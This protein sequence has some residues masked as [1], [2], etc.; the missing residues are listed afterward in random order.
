MVLLGGKKE[1]SEELEDTVE[2]NGCWRTE[3]VV[4]KPKN[5]LPHNNHSL[6]RPVPPFPTRT[7]RT[8]VSDHLVDPGGL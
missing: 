6:D 8:Y 1:S 4:K 5:I 3:Q 7:W 2:G